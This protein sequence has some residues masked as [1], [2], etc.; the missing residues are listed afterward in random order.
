[1]SSKGEMALALRP[2]DTGPFVQLGTLARAP[3]AGGAPREVLEDV[4]WADWTPDGQSLAVVRVSNVSLAHLEFPVGNI[5]Y[6]P[7]GWVSHVRF[8]PNGQFLA[9]GDHIIG[10]NDGRV[11]IVDVHG[12][13]KATSSFYTSMEG[14]A[15]AP[16]GK[17]VW[18]SAATM[19]AQRSIYA[20]DLSGKERLV[21]RAPGGVTIHDISRTGLVLLTA[22]KDRLTISALAPGETQERS[23]TWFDWSLIAD[24]S[25]DGKTILFS[26]T[27][28]A[29]GAVY[30]LYLR[31]TDGSPAVRLGEGGFGSLSPDGKWVAAEVG[32]PAKL[33]LLPTGAGEPKQITDDKGDRFTTLWLPDGKSIVYYGTEPGHGP[34]PYWIDLQGG[35]PRAIAPENT[36]GGIISPDGK[37]LL[38]TDSQHQAWLYPISG[39]EARKLDFTVAANERF[40]RFLDGGKTALLRTRTIPMQ[41]TRVDVATGHR[42]LWKQIVPSDPSG[43]LA[44]PSMKFSA[45]GKSYAYSVGR[46]LSDL[47]VVDGLK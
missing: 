1:M 28:E 13:R 40:V 2:V 19:G 32:S 8:S 3:L 5:L 11:V 38:A 36:G 25:D 7:K 46:R 21:F 33:M 44:I 35:P 34:R 37:F 39:G 9:F 45:D 41:L 29:A 12:S 14:L 20:M 27:G 23:L 6:E 43:V 22:D 17:E 42:Q 15:W 10:G 30:N 26:E 4:Y 16:D 18:Y 47:Y 31:K 24:M